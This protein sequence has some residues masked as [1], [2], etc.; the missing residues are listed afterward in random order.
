MCDSAFRV[1]RLLA[2]ALLCGAAASCARDYSGQRDCPS[3]RLY[4]RVKHAV[5]R[6]ETP[7][8]IGA[9]SIIDDRGRIVTN[10]HVVGKYRE[11]EVQLINGRRFRGRVVSCATRADLALVQ[12]EGAPGGLVTLPVGTTRDVQEGEEIYV[13]GHPLNLGWTLTRG[14]VSRIRGPKEPVMPDTIQVD[15]AVSPGN[16]GGPLISRRGT[17]VGVITLKLV[18]PAAESLNFAIPAEKI[19]DFLAALP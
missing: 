12:M 3:C 1:A 16:S 5:V 14:I 18:A 8:S 19:G 6:I 2:A 4:D 9:G 17:M 13:I 15:A 10:C 11:V 7:T